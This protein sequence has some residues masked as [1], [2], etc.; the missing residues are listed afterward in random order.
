MAKKQSVSSA[1]DLRAKKNAKHISDNK[2][3]FSDVPESTNEELKTARRV[4]RPSSG[5]AKQLIALRLSPELLKKLRKMAERAGKPYQTYIHEM[6]E[7]ITSK[8]A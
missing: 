2:I 1:Q 4:G 6:L 7:K 5:N 3:D 8:A